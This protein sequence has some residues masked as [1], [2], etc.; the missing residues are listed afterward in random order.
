[1]RMSAELF[2]ER[3]Q[4]LDA[5]VHEH[6]WKVLGMSVIVSIL[7]VVAFFD[8]KLRGPLHWRAIR[9]TMHCIKKIP[10]YVKGR[11]EEEMMSANIEIVQS[12][13]HQDTA[14]D[15]IRTLP[16][17]GRDALAIVT[18]LL[19]YSRLQNSGSLERAKPNYMEGA[20]SGA[21]FNTEKN[22]EEQLVTKTVFG[23]TAYS[24][25][26]WPAIFPEIRRMEA[27]VV[28]MTKNL[29]HGGPQVCGTMT[30][31]GSMSILQACLA[32]R[33]RAFDMGINFPEMIMPNS[34]HA[35]FYKA[36]EMFRIKIVEIKVTSATG[37][38]VDPKQVKA[39]ITSNSC[40]IVGSVPNYPY[41]T[42]DDIEALGE[43]GLK[44]GVPLH[45]DACCGGFL[46][47][48]FDQGDAVPAFD[49]RVPGVSSISADT[50]KY[51]LAP[52][53]SSVILYKDKETRAF[54]FYQNV[55]WTGG[56][57]ASPTIEGSRNG[58]AIAVTWASLL[59]N[60]KETLRR[61]A[62]TVRSVTRDLREK[63][64]QLEGMEMMG[65]GDVCIVAWTNTKVCDYKLLDLVEQKGFI[66]SA[67]Q[68]PKGAHLMVTPLHGAP[69]YVD[70][71]VAA[72]REGIK[73]LLDE[74]QLK[75]DGA[76]AMYGM[77][78]AC[79]DRTLVTD[80]ANIYLK[81]LYEFPPETSSYK[82]GSKNAPKR[83]DPEQAIEDLRKSARQLMSE[84][85]S[86]KALTSH[87]RKDTSID[88][89]DEATALLQ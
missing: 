80:V 79:P 33:N 68:F 73:T 45:V 72:L 69:G 85:I 65:Y 75:T 67:L 29:L 83:L 16:E 76:A 18:D 78:I 64:G 60:G 3:L 32:Y 82:Q 34:A 47:P 66:L 61:S 15:W 31:G 6:S 56:I 22:E 23:L 8:Y 28:E 1:L 86:E 25:P 55:D 40:M 50:H 54:G 36:A 13:H 4:Q 48:F 53:G 70:N 52:K 7:T 35:A 37:Y 12:V 24:N 63:I 84:S 11:I 49:F 27:E 74:P 41:G 10:I 59:Y 9:F 5:L 87:L 30:S 19:K 42:T 88:H 38:V 71:L 62:Q 81:T 14:A 43:I 21:V 39:A 2:S 44:S 17:K 77:T 20:V 58:S 89:A 46:I 57:Y 51:G 26:L